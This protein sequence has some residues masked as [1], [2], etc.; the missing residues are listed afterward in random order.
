MQFTPDPGDEVYSC[1]LPIPA[2]S[3]GDFGDRLVNDDSYGGDTNALDSDQ[4]HFRAELV[5]KSPHIVLTGRPENKPRATELQLKHR[6]QL[7][8]FCITSEE[9]FPQIA[10][11]L[12]HSTLTALQWPYLKTGETTSFEART[13]PSVLTTPRGERGLPIALPCTGRFGPCDCAG[14]IHVKAQEQ[15]QQVNS[16][17]SNHLSSQN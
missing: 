9:Y 8:H 17:V 4:N 3:S 5:P 16:A 12:E 1:R 14:V 13:P 10:K 7:R 15:V 6:P 11:T 2:P